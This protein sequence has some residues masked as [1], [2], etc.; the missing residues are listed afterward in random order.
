M[1]SRK[2][3]VLRRDTLLNLISLKL[4][5]LC[6]KC[7]NYNNLIIST[8]SHFSPVKKKQIFFFRLLTAKKH[9]SNIT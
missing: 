7:E 3:N 5:M 4:K 9:F 8:L 1:H 6:S 2:E